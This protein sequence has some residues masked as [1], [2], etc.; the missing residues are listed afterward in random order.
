MQ[1]AAVRA[2]HFEFRN[3]NR[4]GVVRTYDLTE[5]ARPH[6]TDYNC[7]SQQFQGSSEANGLP[8]F[9]AGCEIGEWQLASSCKTSLGNRMDWSLH[10][11]RARG[12]DS[13]G[14]CFAGILQSG[15]SDH[16]QLVASGASLG[17]GAIRGFCAA[18]PEPGTSFRRRARPRPGSPLRLR[19]KSSA[20]RIWRSGI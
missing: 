17:C 11:A 7:Q 19:T 14:G 20:R 15:V 9:Y 12:R 10:G 4:G 3:L 16:L 5:L 6:S 18:R 1:R 13:G 2:Q 8:V